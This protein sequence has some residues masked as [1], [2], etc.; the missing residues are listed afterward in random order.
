MKATLA[1][2][3]YTYTGK[4]IKPAVKVSGLTAS[5]Y[6]VS[7]KNNKN[8]GTATAIIKG[9][10][11]FTGTITKNFKIT[12]AANPVKVTTKKTITIK[13]KKKDYKQKSDNC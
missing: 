6:G 8:V 2:T 10:D 5:D 11:S 9:K 3:S 4:A 7:Y 12:K 1:K 13:A